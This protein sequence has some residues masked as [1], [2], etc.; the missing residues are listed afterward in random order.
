MELEVYSADSKP[1]LPAEH[2]P[3]EA[4]PPPDADSEPEHR[5]TIVEELVQLSHR[6]FP[7]EPGAEAIQQPPIGTPAEEPA[8][9]PQR[10]DA[11]PS[12]VASP[13]SAPAAKVGTALRVAELL[14]QR[15]AT[16]TDA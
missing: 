8:T 1:P 3:P 5:R 12:A 13:A 11:K 4:K 7:R 2:S 10:S 16:L 6:F 15:V 9:Q 14:Q